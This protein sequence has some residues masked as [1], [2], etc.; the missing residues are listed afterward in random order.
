MKDIS[1]RRLKTDIKQKASK[2]RSELFLGQEVKS[3]IAHLEGIFRV[4]VKVMKGDEIETKKVD[5]SKELQK[6]DKISKML[7]SLLESSNSVVEN[8]TE[9]IMEKYNEI[10][11][12]KDIYH[13]AINRESTVREISKQE[14]FN[15]PKLRI[16][17]AK[18]S[19]C[20]SKLDIYGFQSEFTKIYKR[21]TLKR[22]MPDILKNNLLEGSAL[23]LVLQVQEIDEIWTKLKAA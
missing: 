20:N 6:M 8:Q 12:M 13:E 18:F 3:S 1:E 4:D 17:L 15:K 11:K 5:L 16:N 14:L 2:L 23:S 19:G 21:A 7:H 22:V 9:N 10:N